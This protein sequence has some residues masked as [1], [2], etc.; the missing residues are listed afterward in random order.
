M[1]IFRQ[2][3]AQECQDGG[4]SRRGLRL[5]PNARFCEECQ[6][7]LVPV[8]ALSVPRVAL[9]VLAPLALTAAGVSLAFYLAH[10]PQPLDAARRGV[11]DGWVRAA[12]ADAVVNARE[13]AE[14]S[15]IVEQERLEAPLADAYVAEIRGHLEES[16]RALERGAR[17]AGEHRYEEARQEFQRAVDNDPR[18][19]TAWVNLGL[20]KAACGQE[21]EAL[22]P[23]LKA[24]EID[25]E[26]WLAHYNLGLL[27]ARQGDRE[28]A[29]QHLEK[30]LAEV[31]DPASPQRRSMLADLRVS[32][33]DT[34]LDGDPRFAALLTR[35][36]GAAR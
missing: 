13:K 3:I 6:R 21:G 24:L 7:P 12:F 1:S 15:R 4:C 27:L 35:M 32:A 20:A 10:R 17:L 11:L 8:A 9:A 14:L 22:A 26:S 28:Q 16:R 19:A 34:P 2:V 29:L 18:N 5:D 31:P 25:P 33:G 36:E 23:Y 30:A